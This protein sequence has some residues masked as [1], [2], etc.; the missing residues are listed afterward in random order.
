M[1]PDYCAEDIITVILDIIFLILGSFILLTILYLFFLAFAAL[2][3]EKRGRFH[4]PAMKFAIVIPAHNEAKVIQKTLDS[5]RSVDY[6]KNLYEVIVIADNCEDNTA[7]ISGKAGVK[8]L[9]RNNPELRGKS[10]V[11]QWAFEHLLKKGNHDVF[12]VI[13]ADTIV[14]PNFLNA[15]NQRIIEGAKAVQGYYDVLHPE[16]SPMESLYFLSFVISRNLRY[17]GRTRL[18]WTSNL[19]GSGMCFT[20]E[21]IKRFGWCANSIVEDIEYEMILHLNGIR[22]VFAP[23]AKIY[24]EIPDTFKNAET[25]RGRW[26]IGKFKI[27]NRYLPKLVWEGIK[28]RDVSYFDSAMELLIPPFSHFVTLILTFFL[29]FILLNFKGFNLNFYIWM[30]I[31]GGLGTYIAG[32]LISARASLKIYLTLIYAP[33]FLLW[34]FWV[35]IKDT[36][37]KKQQI[38]VKTERK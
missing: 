25:Q 27:R 36:I 17:N 12:A 15:M 23:E 34:R 1:V 38:W 8:C 13:D 20:R 35:I 3:P 19:L 32:G 33:F 26:D 7:E 18:G 10:Y 28:R 21:V 6:P 29:L 24:A 9:E 22:V 2:G 11:L 37:Q 30:I 16:R 14:E 4:P 31:I 5:F